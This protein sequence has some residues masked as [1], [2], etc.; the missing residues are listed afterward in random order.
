MKK[1]NDYE[2]TGIDSMP[3]SREEDPLKPV[4]NIITV[5]LTLYVGLKR[6]ET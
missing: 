5:A 3:P 2:S 1:V 4:Q 6:R